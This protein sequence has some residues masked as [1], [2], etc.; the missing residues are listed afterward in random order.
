MAEKGNEFLAQILE[1][2]PSQIDYTAIQIGNVKLG[3][4]G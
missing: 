4:E 2:N 1:K 3:A